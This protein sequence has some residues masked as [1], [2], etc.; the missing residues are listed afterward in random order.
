MEVLLLTT[1]NFPLTEEVLSGEY[2]L[3]L[4]HVAMHSFDS[5]ATQAMPPSQRATHA[6]PLSQLFTYL[7]VQQ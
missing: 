5:R 7:K 3:P 1:I 4:M 2:Q 6:M